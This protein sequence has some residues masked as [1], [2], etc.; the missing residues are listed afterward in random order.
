MF[1]K[2]LNSRPIHAI[3]FCVL[4]ANVT[5][6]LACTENKVHLPAETPQVSETGALPGTDVA[7]ASDNTTKA[8]EAKPMVA[9]TPNTQIPAK[10]TT[11][12]SES[13]TRV[14]GQVNSG[15]QGQA[16]FKVAGH[17]SK[18]IVQV[19]E[20]IR[21][22]QTLAV[23]DDTDAQLRL[24]IAQNQIELARVSLDQANKD[25]ERELQL[26]KEGATT[27]TNLERISNTLANSKINYSQAQISLQQAQKN[28]GDSRLQ[29]AFDG[30]VARRL[31]VEG[32]YVGVGAAVYE[33]ASLSELEVSLRVPENLIKKV[34][35]GH[36]INLSIPSLSKDTQAKIL[37]IVPVIQENSR[38]FEVIGRIQGTLPGELVPGQFVEAQL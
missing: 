14:S 6:L 20:K 12:P 9:A 37:R 15:K 23:L 21:R 19:G 5:Y 11:E 13:L 22:G 3:Y 28:L 4:S 18:T 30:V 7:V 2:V 27:Q 25:M 1:L 38:T 24:K 36:Q 29:A 34:K 8:P 17:I 16:S 33:L 31:K 35:P 26:K 10:P 32:E